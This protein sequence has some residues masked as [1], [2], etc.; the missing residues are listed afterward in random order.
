[1]YH[2]ILM[3]MLHQLKLEV[4]RLGRPFHE[5]LCRV[6]AHITR[7]LRVAPITRLDACQPSPVTQSELILLGCMGATSHDLHWCL[8][9]GGL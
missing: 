1:M 8:L 5:Y 4:L 7:D 6:F 2:L 9:E 3:L